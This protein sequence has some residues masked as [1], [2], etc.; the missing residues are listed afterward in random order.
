MN[1]EDAK[2]LA[3]LTKDVVSFAKTTALN[4]EEKLK[5]FKGAIERIPPEDRPY[6]GDFIMIEIAAAAAIDEP[7]QEEGEM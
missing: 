1:E 7:N 5:G 6:I 2:R 3:E 4:R